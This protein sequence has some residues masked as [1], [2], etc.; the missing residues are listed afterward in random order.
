MSHD[1]SDS[2]RLAEPFEQYPDDENAGF[3]TVVFG[4]VGGGGTRQ[5]VI[6]RPDGTLL[7]DFTDPKD[8]RETNWNPERRVKLLAEA[9]QEANR[10]SDWI[11]PNDDLDA[12][13]S[14]GPT[15]NSFDISITSADENRE[16]T[17]DNQ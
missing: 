7:T 13:N 8:E 17:G 3:H 12:Q 2:D 11:A 6:E 5:I 9:I 10:E 14:V 4:R 15:I 1:D 16:T